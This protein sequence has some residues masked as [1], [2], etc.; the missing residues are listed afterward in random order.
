M[1][2]LSK[3]SMA[4]AFA[5]SLG[6]ASPAWAEEIVY[7]QNEA[8]T[9]AILQPAPSWMAGLVAPALFPGSMASPSDSGNSV[10]VDYDPDVPSA[11]HPQ[12]V[13]GGLSQNG[14]AANNAASIVNGSIS[15]SAYGGYSYNGNATGN[16]LIMSGGA[17]SG[18][19]HGGYSYN[20]E[21]TGNFL[22]ISGGSVSGSAYSGYSYTSN[23]SGNT[24]LMTGG[25]VGTLAGGSSYSGNITGNTMIVTGGEVSTLV[26][27]GHGFNI[28]ASTG[29]T[30]IIAGAPNLGGAV[31]E[32]GFV[33]RANGA[34][35]FT[36][37][38]LNVNGFRG[39]VVRVRNFEFYN[40][41]LP[42]GLA[43][44][45]AVLTIT[46]GT[47]VDL[48]N[49][50]AAIVGMEPGV[51]LNPGDSVVLISSTTGTPATASSFNTQSPL[52]SYQ[53]SLFAD[54][55]L[56]AT[57]DSVQVTPSAKTLLEGRAAGLGFLSQGADLVAGAGMDSLLAQTRQGGLGAFG[58]MAGG[59]SRY[60]SGSH[61]DVSGFSLLA[62]LGWRAARPAMAVGAFFEA[63][64]GNYDSYNS[65]ANLPSA[66]GNG[67]PG[68]YG[69]GLLGRF[70]FLFSQ[71]GNVYAEASLRMGESDNDFNS[72]D[73]GYGWDVSYDSSVTY[74]GAHAGLGYLWQ[75]GEKPLLDTYVKY[76]WTRQ[77]SDSVTVL[78]ESVRFDAA[79][80]HRLRV[81]ARLSVKATEAVTPYMGAAYEYEFD[82]KAGGNVRGYSIEA[83][84]LSGSTGMG[85]LGL[86]VQPASALPLYLDLG[87]QGYVGQRQGVSGSLQ[88]KWRF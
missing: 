1:N 64:W 17:I 75:L 39:A 59:W 33:T 9:G 28:G 10:R 79:D 57:L 15:G 88:I 42:A 69:G 67:N 80:S 31:L 86:S 18:N 40:F 49:T 85:E 51:S 22:N 29:N 77:D 73:L 47:P 82:G 38:T 72:A 63:G 43:N 76:L 2:I 65:F 83:A 45:D 66:K 23:V 78:G 58:A 54:N 8:S 34:D 13:F 36:G 62:G 50:H 7:G 14:E 55:A 26:S 27:G 25:K 70:D 71:R 68:Y 24:V 52:L 87:V 53:F 60:R 46:G 5:L 3:H 11:S 41:V 74:Y 6:L 61:V 48:T 30:V 19:V 21:V 35:V 20:G 12:T 16:V 56:R 84:D 4:A 81:G 32:G 44:G 37:N